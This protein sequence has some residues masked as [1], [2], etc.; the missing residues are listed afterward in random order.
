MCGTPGTP[1]RLQTLLVRDGW[2]EQGKEPSQSLGGERRWTQGE[3]KK[4]GGDV[5]GNYHLGGDCHLTARSSSQ[6]RSDR[7]GGSL[8]RDLRGR[9]KEKGRTG[10]LLKGKSNALDWS[11]N[12]TVKTDPRGKVFV[13][14]FLF[15]VCKTLIF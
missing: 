12:P 6:Q 5:C 15:K 10:H 4:T 2:K 13:N 14:C 8:R 7:K 9:R 1:S 3:E 11:V